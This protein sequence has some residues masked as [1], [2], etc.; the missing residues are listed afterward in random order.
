MTPC[1]MEPEEASRPTEDLIPEPSPDARFGLP[2]TPPDGSFKNLTRHLLARLVSRDELGAE[3]SKELTVP[4]PST[5]VDETDELHPASCSMSSSVPPLP[6]PLND[7]GILKYH[8][9]ALRLEAD[10]HPLRLALSRLMAH[11]THNRKGMFNHPVDPIALGL[12]DY[13]L[14]VANPMDLGSIK[15]RLHALAY[16][17]RAQVVDDIRLVFSN[18]MRY[19]P[20]HHSVHK[21]AK[22]LVAYFESYLGALGPCVSTAAF[23]TAEPRANV[24]LDASA[25]KD[26]PLPVTSPAFLKRDTSKD[27]LES[28]I[29]C[30]A[31]FAPCHIDAD[32]S[33]SRLVAQPAQPATA[34]VARAGSTSNTEP[35]P[36]AFQRTQ[37]LPSFSK[38]RVRMAR[39]RA[40]TSNTRSGVSHA[41][42][43]CQGRTCLIC[44]QGCL[45]H[46]PALLVCCGAHCGGARIRKG[47][48][49]YI[50]KDGTHQFCERCYNG[51]PSTLL[52]SVQ[53]EALRYKQELLKR[54][55]DEEIAEDWITCSECLGGVHSVCAMHNEYVHDASKYACPECAWKSTDHPKSSDRDPKMWCTMIGAQNEQMYTFVSGLAEPVPVTSIKL[56]SYPILNSESLRECSISTFIEKKVQQVMRG[57]PNAEKTIKI[58]VISDCYRLFSVPDV[59][60]RYFRM[61]T[62]TNDLIPPPASVHYR[63]KAITM[64]QKI[65]GLDVCIFCMYVQEYDDESSCGGSQ[66][67]RVYIAYIDSVEHFRPR[68]SRTQVFHEILIAYLAT[69]RERGYHTAQIWACPPSRG[70]SFVFWNHPASQRT[71]TKDRLLT[72]YHGALS[73]AIEFGV[74]TDVKSLFESDFEKSL[75]DISFPETVS[76]AA[77]ASILTSERMVCPPLVDGDFWIEE[78]VRI[79]AT[80]VARYGKVRMPTEVCVWNVSSLADSEL[81][82]CPALQLAALLKDRIMT[83]PSSVPFRRPV[84]AVALK[85]KDYHKIVKQPTDLGTIFSRCVLGQYHRV[86][87]VVKDVE[88]M[89][90]NAKMFNPPGH[91]VYRQA[92]EVLSLFYAELTSLVQLW[93]CQKKEK[94]S[95]ESH[96]EVSMSLNATVELTG[97][98]YGPRS[99]IVLIE[100]DRSSDDSRSLAT[101]QRSPVTTLMVKTT[102]EEPSSSQVSPTADRIVK[103]LSKRKKHRGRPRP[104]KEP[105]KKLEIL[106]GGP[107]AIAQRMVGEDLW[108]LDKRNPIP[109]KEFKPASGKKRVRNS[110]TLCEEEHPSKKRRQS[111]LC[112]EIGQTIRNL[113]TSFFSCSLN[114]ARVMSKAEVDKLACY[115]AYVSGF[116]CEDDSDTIPMPSSLADTRSALLELSQY[117]HF[118]FDTL[119][120]AKYSTNMLLYHIHN[121]QAPGATPVCTSCGKAIAQVRWHKAKKIREIRQPPATRE[122]KFFIVDDEDKR[123]LWLPREDLCT[124]CHDERDLN[125]DYIPIP[126]HEHDMEANAS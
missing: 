109:P 62:N 108:L 73:R 61:A 19:N 68:E 48:L 59:V 78:T 50:T 105:F 100:D 107:E 103:A 52:H 125:D 22:E 46:E 94:Q 116:R 3:G 60:Q 11:P 12:A 14:I 53:N 39:G 92:D 44:R 88:R 82:P 119:R 15:R 117:R 80:N 56:T 64:F 55:N 72:W 75:S 97:P 8:I 36:S 49:Y 20:P 76:V 86:K 85:L 30:D 71:P 95:W 25:Q 106:S 33:T 29:P 42:Q 47:S 87:D 41:C 67:K 114:P 58:R 98:K 70:N 90:S 77:D 18:A 31:A 17:S 1:T 123:R 6:N 10:L 112:E 66:N 91:S 35:V 124:A 96:S 63:Q 4:F 45:Q 57:T 74:V 110:T 111:W 54:R 24:A 21:C 16:Q 113:R 122:S 7:T 32:T 115:S 40:S 34:G 120:R 5:A 37:V 13:H 102:E 26:V 28:C 2:E 89:V 84:N 93:R 104:K 79:H 99:P 121:S 27:I 43:Q 81:D 65:D 101:I 69:A 38:P 23:D 9:S 83:H 126:V 118:E 51:L